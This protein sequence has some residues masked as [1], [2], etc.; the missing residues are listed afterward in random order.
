M[1]TA[2]LVEI[3]ASAPAPYSLADQTLYGRAIT[4][5]CAVHTHGGHLLHLCDGDRTPHPAWYGGNVV[6]AIAEASEAEAIS[7]L[8]TTTGHN[9]LAMMVGD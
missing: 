9:V 5:A 8:E 3:D 1:R 4:P 2:V 7:V 6:A